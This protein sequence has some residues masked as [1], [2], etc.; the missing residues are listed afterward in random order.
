MGKVVLHWCWMN[1]RESAILTKMINAYLWHRSAKSI[2]INE[3][4]ITFFLPSMPFKAKKVKNITLNECSRRKLHFKKF[5]KIIFKK[6]LWK[7]DPEDQPEKNQLFS[8]KRWVWWVT[9]YT[10]QKMKFS[11]KD[12]FS[13]CDQIRRKLWIWSHLLKKTLIEN[14]IFCAV[15]LF[16]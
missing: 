14:L 13:T 15:L 3:T 7:K 1:I 4:T 8:F 16:F 12:F 10:A 11:I 6:D 5:I 2:M 9:I